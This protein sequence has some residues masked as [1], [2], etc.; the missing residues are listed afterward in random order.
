MRSRRSPEVCIHVQC[1][2]LSY[3]LSLCTCNVC[4]SMCVCVY[5][6]C[7]TTLSKYM[8]IW[9]LSVHVRVAITV[10]KSEIAFLR[11]CSDDTT[12]EI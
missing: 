1:I 7:V 9:A 3:L 6:L 12:L 5:L 10:Y 2:H 4:E 11:T 8:Y